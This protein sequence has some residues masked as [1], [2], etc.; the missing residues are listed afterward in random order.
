MNRNK[1][2]DLARH[3]EFDGETRETHQPTCDARRLKN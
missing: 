3:P 1:K 2:A